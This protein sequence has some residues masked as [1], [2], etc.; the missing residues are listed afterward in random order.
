VY[1]IEKRIALNEKRDKELN[2]IKDK[3]NSNERE[4]N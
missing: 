4:I 3:I 2:I 1:N